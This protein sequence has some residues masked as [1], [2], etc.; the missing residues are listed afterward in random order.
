MIGSR[1]LLPYYIHINVYF[2]FV[3]LCTFGT[4]GYLRYGDDVSQLIVEKIT[5]HTTMSIIVDV[6]LV[7]SVLFTYPLQCFPVI[8]ILESYLFQN[9]KDYWYSVG[10]QYA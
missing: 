4:L 5:Q 6:T 8:E 3:I 2:V 7:I 10:K 9:G 1:H